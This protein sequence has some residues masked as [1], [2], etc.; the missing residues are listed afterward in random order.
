MI[1][2]DFRKL[3]TIERESTAK[4]RVGT[5]TETYT[6]LKQK[7]ADLYVA[8]GTSQ[9]GQEGTLPFSADIFVIRYDAD[10]DYKCRII[11]N[12]NYY[13]IEHIEEVGRKQFMRIKT[14][15]WERA[16]IYF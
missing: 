7:Y 13:K 2:S 6:F 5:Q 11:Y 8:G 14:V 10:V 15:V 1:T 16:T 3:I 12:N 4:N 9:Y